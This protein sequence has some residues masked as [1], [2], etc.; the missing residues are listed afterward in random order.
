[1]TE[2]LSLNKKYSSFNEINTSYEAE[3]DIRKIER[4]K[5]I[6]SSNPESSFNNLNSEIKLIL[7]IFMIPNIGGL[8][9]KYIQ[10]QMKKIL[11]MKAKMKRGPPLKKIIFYLLKIK[12]LQNH[13]IQNLLNYKIWGE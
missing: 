1:M 11:H 7:N 8:A 2:A 5:S 10:K 12:I 3:T 9:K 13:F 6:N 4:K